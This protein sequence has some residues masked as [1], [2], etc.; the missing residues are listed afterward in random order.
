MNLYLSPNGRIDQSTYW[1]GVITL[2]VISAV[3][4]VLSAFVSPF[5]GLLG[6][7]VVWP[8]IVLHVK[9][10]HDADQTG[11]ITIG[12]V[13]LAIILST[14]LSFILP[15]LFGVDAAALQAEMMRDMEDI[16]SSNDPGAVLAASME[17]SK[18]VAQAQL[19]PSILSTAIVTGVIGFVMSLFKSTPGPNKYGPPSGM[20][21]VDTFA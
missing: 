15:A 21:A 13:V 5:L 20:G 9:R 16:S 7:V 19:L 6:L 12:M 10:F 3:V 18:K 2:F 1:R 17:A 8:W 11:W 4:S 14:V